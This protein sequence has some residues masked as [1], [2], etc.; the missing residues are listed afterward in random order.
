MSLL[1][2]LL[3]Y[4]A[5]VPPKGSEEYRL[6]FIHAYENYGQYSP[7]AE[8][9]KYL[10]T[11]AL[12][13]FGT[14]AILELGSGKCKTVSNLLAGIPSDTNVAYHS[15]DKYVYTE[16]VYP[17]LTRTHHRGC[18][19]QDDTYTN[20]PKDCF[21]ILIV[22]V[23]PHG[24]E[25]ELVQKCQPFMKQEYIVIFKC[26]GFMDMW[27]YDLAVRTLTYMKDHVK[28]IDTVHCKDSEFRDVIALCA[29]EGQ[30]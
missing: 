10:A 16:V 23:E 22:D 27:C 17:A 3:S 1:D 9:I 30:V 18:A 21:N 13:R 7:G 8:F 2:A 25:I 20:I 29:K 24:K 19:F 26:I 12:D 4:K 6:A 11:V 5:A 28:L 14:I 15:I